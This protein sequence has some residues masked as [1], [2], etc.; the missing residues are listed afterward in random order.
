LETIVQA[1][2]KG[3]A[4]QSVPIRV[5]P[6]Q[7]PSRLIKNIF[8]YIKRSIAI[9]VRISVVYRP[10]R[11]FMVIGVTLFALGFLIGLRFLYFY[12]SGHGQGHIQ[13][14]I[15]ASILLAFGFQ[16]I[17]IAFISDLLATNRKI[18]EEMQ[19]RLKK[20]ETQKMESDNLPGE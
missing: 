14:L 3:L 5:N 12:F 7:R 11:F 9:L 16:T 2:Q 17:L 15:L 6:N 13:S 8:T 20:I 19:A 4:V 10:F 18:I 1:G